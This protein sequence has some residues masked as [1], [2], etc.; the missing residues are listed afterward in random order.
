MGE[1]HTVLFICLL[2]F[3]LKKTLQNKRSLNPA[4]FRV[5]A[6]TGSSDSQLHKAPFSLLW[7]N[8]RTEIS[9]RTVAACMELA[10]GFNAIPDPSVGG[11]S[12]S[13]GWRWGIERGKQGGVVAR[14]LWLFSAEPWEA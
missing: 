6:C 7:Q 2:V 13:I 3:Q 11:K 14:V 5:G 12:G 9:P 10:Y 8:K 4:V 1:P